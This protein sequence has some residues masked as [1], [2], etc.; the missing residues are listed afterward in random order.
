LLDGFDVHLALNPIG[1]FL[2]G[3]F[4]LKLVRKLQPVSIYDERL[5]FGLIRIET[6]DKGRLAKQEIEMVNCFE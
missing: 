4:L 5:F 2:G 6:I 1:A 3:A